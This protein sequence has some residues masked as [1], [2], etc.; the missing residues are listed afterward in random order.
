ME[1]YLDL[2]H[3]LRAELESDPEIIKEVNE[4]GKAIYL[5][6]SL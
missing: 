5:R 2:Y 6:E 4:R 3:R 1:D